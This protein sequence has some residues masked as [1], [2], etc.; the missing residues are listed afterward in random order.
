MQNIYFLLGYLS[1]Q[2]FVVLFTGQKWLWILAVGAGLWFLDAVL[3]GALWVTQIMSHYTG[4]LCV[5]K[6][7]CARDTYAEGV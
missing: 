5:L 2:M 1:V 3:P 4:N 7:V 6:M